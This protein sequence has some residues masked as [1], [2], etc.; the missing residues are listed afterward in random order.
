MQSQGHR[1]VMRD[2][3]LSVEAAEDL[4]FLREGLDQVAWVVLVEECCDL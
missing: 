1:L 3:R 2:L 4:G